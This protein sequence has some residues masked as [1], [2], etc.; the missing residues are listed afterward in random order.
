MTILMHD[1][2]AVVRGFPESGVTKGA[3]GTV[4]TVFE[5]P[6]SALEVEF[7]DERGTTTA[8]LVLRPDD[9][10]LI[11]RALG[12]VVGG[13]KLLAAANLGDEAAIQ[14]TGAPSAWWP[15][16][17]TALEGWFSFVAR[18][19]QLCARFMLGLARSMLPA[20][21]SSPQVSRDDD[22]LERILEKAELALGGVAVSEDEWAELESRA[23]ALYDS[24]DGVRLRQGLTL[25]AVV[26]AFLA[27]VCTQLYDDGV[28]LRQARLATL[29]ATAQ[30][31]AEQPGFDHGPFADTAREVAR[32]LLH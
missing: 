3:R 11:S 10:V 8:Q 26:T 13:E 15:Q 19:P 29:T 4:V 9:V 1:V 23:T 25:D 20:W 16:D 17:P 12:A 5:H 14:A 32:W 30:A 24:A 6:V 7:C 18:D 22:T 2:V 21:R 27:L 31:I 28:P